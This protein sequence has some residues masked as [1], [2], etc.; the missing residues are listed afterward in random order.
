MKV[1]SADSKIQISILKAANDI[2]LENALVLYG[3]IDSF[4][5]VKSDAYIPSRT[6]PKVTYSSPKPISGK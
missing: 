2:A 1:E 4:S 3:S 6:V 5:S